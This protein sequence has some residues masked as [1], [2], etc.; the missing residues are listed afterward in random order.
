MKKL[1]CF[2]FICLP[3]LS[4]AQSSDSLVVIGKKDSIFSAS[5]KETR[6]YLIHLPAN[7][8]SGFIQPAK[9]PVLYLLDGDAHFNSVSGLVEILG[10]GINGTHVIPDMIVVAIP[11]T[12]RTRDLTPTHAS[13]DNSGKEQEFFKTSGGN[14]NFLKFIKKELIPHIDST[15]RTMPYR[16]FVGHSFGGITVIN[17]LYTIPETFD[18]YIA[19]DPSLWWDHKVLLEKAKEYFL[20]ANLDGKSLYM[21]QANTMVTGDTSINEHFESI[22]EFAT[23]LQSRNRSGLQWKY[24]YYGDD[25]H[26]SVPFISEY[27]GLRFIFNDYHIKTTETL[28]EP[29]KLKAQFQKFSEETNVKFMPPEDVI[30]SLGYNFLG[31]D[32]TDLAI[33]YFQMNIDYYPESSNVYDSMGEAW[34]KKGDNNKAIEYYKKSLSL[35]PENQNAKDMIAKM[36]TS[37]KGNK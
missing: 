35:N 17:A 21:G 34:M 5:L 9:Y 13:K 18:A 24:D 23:L 31:N 10:G 16:V 7:Y 36:Q 28:F 15:Y 25:D 14:D 4:V 29:D 1:F 20:H 33:K 19:I 12:D 8:N 27:N 22:K 2:L 30:N 37:K 32:K 26:G 11:N 3:F 6:H